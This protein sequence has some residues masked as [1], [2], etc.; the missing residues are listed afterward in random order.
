MSYI[1]EHFLKPNAH[2]S[3]TG[4]PQFAGFTFDHVCNGTIEAQGEDPFA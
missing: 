1:I 4:D 2:A 3:S